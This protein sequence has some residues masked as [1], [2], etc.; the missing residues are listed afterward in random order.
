MSFFRPRLNPALGHH[1]TE[2]LAEVNRPRR[3]RVIICAYDAPRYHA[4]GPNTWL[5][6]LLPDLRD[7][8]IEVITLVIHSGS[9]LECPLISGLRLQG[10]DV[11]DLQRETTPFVEDQVRWI[12]LQVKKVKPHVFIANLVTPAFYAGQWVK[13]AGIPVVGVFH[14]DEPFC[15]A[16]AT[17]F[18]GGRAA[19]SFSA[20]V[21]VSEFLTEK[22]AKRNP[23]AA[24][25]VRIPCGAPIP[26]DVPLRQSELLRVLYL[27]RI[28]QVPKKILDIADAFCLA[29]RTL[30]ATRYTIVGGGPDEEKLKEVI[31]REACHG[32]VEFAGLVDSANVPQL[33]RENDVIVFFSAY[34]GLPIALIEGMSYGL[35]PVC[36]SER[37]GIDEVVKNDVNGIII[38][39]DPDSFVAAIERL[40]RDPGLRKRLAK[41][42]R[43]TAEEE[44]STQVNNLRWIQLI[45]QLSSSAAPKPTRQPIWLRLP[46]PHPDFGTED[47]R[48][49][50]LTR[51]SHVALQRGWFNLRQTLR[52]RSRIRELLGS[53][54]F[55]S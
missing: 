53:T 24:D 22:V 50:S 49:P 45:G 44:Y 19:D 18:V 4:G 48:K 23:H 32:M 12:L 54:R 40:Q 14:C 26:N 51:R 31:S 29:A 55:D 5:K 37:S 27:G 46:E 36:S 6:R 38:D 21:C 30:P 42:A 33:L 1:L 41:T 2:L 47:L 35:I 34:E 52:P 9:D 8:G 15:D 39:G 10:F 43:L 17:R 16:M 25:I 13:K 11:R 28:S 7:A 20:A 3:P